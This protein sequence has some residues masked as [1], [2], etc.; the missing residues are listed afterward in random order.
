MDLSIITI[1]DAANADV[2]L[3]LQSQDKLKSIYF[4]AASTLELPEKFEVSHDLKQS[5]AK[6][7]DRHLVKYLKT[8]KDSVTGEIYTLVCSLQ[9]SVPRGYTASDS[10]VGDLFAGITSYVGTSGTVTKLLDGVTP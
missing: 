10:D 6:G 9:I 1:K 2:S 5:G 4:N 7:S 8:Q 3:D